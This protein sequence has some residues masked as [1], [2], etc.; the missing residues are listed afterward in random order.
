MGTAVSRHPKTLLHTPDTASA[1][2]DF[3]NWNKI[4]KDKYGPSVDRMFV[5]EGEPCDAVSDLLLIIHH[6]YTNKECKLV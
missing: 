6:Y 4:Y 3:D 2:E 5:L 1:K